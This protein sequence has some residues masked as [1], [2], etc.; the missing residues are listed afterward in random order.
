VLRCAAPLGWP[1]VTALSSSSGGPLP[2]D[3]AFL[4]VEDDPAD[5]ELLRV[6]LAGA[7]VA[8]ATVVA[9]VEDALTH[10]KHTGRGPTITVTDLNMPGRDGFA[11]LKEVRGDPALAHTPVVVLSTSARPQDLTRALALGANA[12]HVKP[13]DMVDFVAL[14]RSL[15]AYWRRV[16]LVAP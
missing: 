10:L 16:V 9:T 13:A 14:L 1:P 5:E 8:N 2:V 11:L 3:P 7:E 15:A 12:Y 4:F 6:A